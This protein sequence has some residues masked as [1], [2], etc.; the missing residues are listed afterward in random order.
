VSISRRYQ[1]LDRQT[2]NYCE[3][4]VEINNAN[5]NGPT[6]TAISGS[7]IVLPSIYW[8]S[9]DQRYLSSVRHY[10]EFTKTKQLSRSLTLLY[11]LATFPT[12]LGNTCPLAIN[13][14]CRLRFSC[15]PVFIFSLFFVGK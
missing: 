14:K 3:N 9:D 15:F 5:V 4:C 6:K 7:C 11:F 12:R 10:H 1:L 13:Q 2:F 8:D